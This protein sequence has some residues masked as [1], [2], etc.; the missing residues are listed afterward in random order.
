MHEQNEIMQ[1][2]L[3]DLKAKLS[4]LIKAIEERTEELDY[5]LYCF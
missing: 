4:N 2:G 1:E 3:E 5:P